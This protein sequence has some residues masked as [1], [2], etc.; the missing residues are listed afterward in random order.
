MGPLVLLLIAA[1]VVS[2]T[3]AMSCLKKGSQDYRW[4]FAGVGFYTLT[5]YLLTKTFQLESMALT[6]ALWS[7][8]SVMATTTVGVLAFK[9]VLHIHDYAAIAMIGGGV[10]ILKYTH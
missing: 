3:C 7:A 6:N 2:E 10:V 8:V 4:F 9:E 1:I 5:A